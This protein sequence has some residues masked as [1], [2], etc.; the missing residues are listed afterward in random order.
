MTRKRT[1]VRGRQASSN[2][3]IGPRELARVRADGPE[4]LRWQRRFGLAKAQQF[5]V[6]LLISGVVP[7]VGLLVLGWNVAAMLVFIVLDVLAT[8]LGDVVKQLLAGPVVRHTHARDHL[9]QQVLSII[10][11]L[12]DGTNTWIDH[13]RGFSPLGL[14]WISLGCAV[15]FV[16]VMAASIEA[17]GVGSVREAIEA[18]WFVEIAIGTVALH[19]LQSGFAA[20]AA[21][22]KAP[23]EHALY[24]DS[25][26]VIGLLVGMMFL[27]WLPGIWG[28]NGVIAMLVVIF[29]FKLGFGAFALYWIPRVTRA[30]QR[31][32]ENPVSPSR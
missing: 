7:F 28:A 13:G 17:L 1:T 9:T 11:G 15:C 10:G 27:V 25:G 5:C 8:L 23:D 16:P 4:A 30:L 24:L 22:G 3:P 2:L 19:L 26:G 32:L 12:E 20:F 6:G 21:R 14:F 31:F 18:T 29:V